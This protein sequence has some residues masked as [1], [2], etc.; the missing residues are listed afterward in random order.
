MRTLIRNCRIASPGVD[1]P[2]GNL[3]LENGRIAAVGNTPEHDADR[4]IDGK[5]LTAVPG[6]IDIHSH[7]RS[8]YDFCDGTPETFAAIG[9]G[10]LQDGVTGFLA[11]SLSVSENDLRNL[12]RQAEWYKK[13]VPDGASMLGIHLEGPFFNPPCA[14]A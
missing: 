6:F 3:L 9:Q 2:E 14:G 7:G 4:V 12:C 13:N 10:K 11:T 1:I 5:G 8:N